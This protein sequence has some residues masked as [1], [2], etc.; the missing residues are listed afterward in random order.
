[1]EVNKMPGMDGTG[2]DG[3]GPMTGRGIGQCGRG[4]GRGLG[5]GMGRG[6]GCGRGRG[7]GMSYGRTPVSLTPAEEKKILEAELSEIDKEKKEI[8]QRLKEL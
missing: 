2:P 1:M 5:R 4:Y 3:R 7:F 8:E 6:F